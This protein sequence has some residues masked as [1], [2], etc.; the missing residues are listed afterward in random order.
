MASAVFTKL[1]LGAHTEI[2]VLQ[3]PEFFA[4]ALGSLDGV[5]VRTSLRGSAPIVFAL[6]FV[7]R[8]AE[9]EALAPALAARMP[10]DALLWFAYPKGT[11]KRYTCD[12]NRDTGWASVGAQ[13]FEPVRSAAIDE[14]WT[15]MRFRRVEY[16]RSFTRDAKRVLSDGGKAR[17]AT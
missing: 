1:N 4:P 6:V 3:A 10:G 12:F 8:L 5:T 13:G 9:V 15:A 11:S 14:D 2:T 7:T 17:K 16:I